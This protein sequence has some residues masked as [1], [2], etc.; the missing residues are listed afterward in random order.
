MAVPSR[1][2]SERGCARHGQVAGGDALGDLGLLAQ[3]DEHASK[4]AAIAPSS[5]RFVTV[6]V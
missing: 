5:S 1:S 2:R 3:V 6:I 4:A